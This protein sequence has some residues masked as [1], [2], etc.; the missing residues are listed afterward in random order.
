MNILTSLI[1]SFVMV[2][3]I[4]SPRESALS[5]QYQAGNWN[6]QRIG[7]FQPAEV[8]DGVLYIGNEPSDYPADSSKNFYVPSICSTE[9]GTWFVS[10][11][12]NYKLD[13]IMRCD[14]RG[15]NVKTIDFRSRIDERTQKVEVKMSADKTMINV[16]V[17]RADNATTYS[18]STDP[19]EDIFITHV[20]P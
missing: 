3:G 17:Q 8:R 20:Q 15:I 11:L 13:L 10:A 12:S 1:L 6:G 9:K 18:F 5:R 19:D 7:F 16:I 4:G 2:F 14:K